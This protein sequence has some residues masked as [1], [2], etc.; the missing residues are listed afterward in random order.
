MSN[1]G[2]QI[3]ALLW[4]GD[5]KAAFNFVPITEAY[6]ALKLCARMRLRCNV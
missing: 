6:D 5:M 2:L 4:E 3:P 1:I